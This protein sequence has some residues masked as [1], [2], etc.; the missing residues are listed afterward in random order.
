LAFNIKDIILKE[1]FISLVILCYA[2]FTC[3]QDLV[4]L[5][6]GSKMTVEIIETTASDI[7]YKRYSNLPAKNDQMYTMNKSKL[8]RILYKDGREEVFNN[9]ELKNPNLFS[10]INPAK[11]NSGR[12]LSEKAGYPIG[13][14]YYYLGD[15]PIKYKEFKSVL[16]NNKEAYQLYMDNRWK[17]DLS[18]SACYLGFITAILLGTTAFTGDYDKEFTPYL[19][20]SLAV[21]GFTLPISIK[22]DKKRR[23]A[24]ELF[25]NRVKGL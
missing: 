8:H 4:T 22:T 5:I 23:K 6:D 11:P 7:V 2:H 10:T 9:V 18:S 20:G 1:I 25:N 17:S 14:I 24:V 3:A 12:L 21:A 16:S 15:T 19:I 13:V